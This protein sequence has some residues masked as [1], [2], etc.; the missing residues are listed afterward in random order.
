MK[1][2]IYAFSMVLCLFLSFSE[3]NAQTE[4]DT[5]VQSQSFMIEMNNGDIYTGY[6]LSKTQKNIVLQ[7]VNGEIN[8]V[9]QNIKSIKKNDYVGEFNY[10]SPNA[11][12][13]FFGPSAIP[14]KAGKGYY[15]NILVSFN[16]FNY[17]ITDNFSIGGGFEVVSTLLGQPIW[18]LTPKFGVEVGDNVHVG[19]GLLTIGLA[20]E[21]SFNIGYGVFTKGDAD[22]NF[23]FGTGFGFANGELTSKP[24]F[25]VSGTHRTSKAISLMTENYLF[26]DSTGS[27]S[28]FGIQGVR[29]ISRNN[30]FDIGGMF[31]G[32]FGELPFI[33]YIGYV[34]SF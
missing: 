4:A 18:F 20:S 22:S 7:T 31:S 29:F 23:S 15:Q 24:S 27:F 26:P 12:R 13:Y 17:G 3:V 6:I 2:T 21:G 19:A 32:S 16:F 30:S 14:L 25:M 1:N 8:I 28:Y 9:S 10:E 33:P 11:T 34:R 5:L